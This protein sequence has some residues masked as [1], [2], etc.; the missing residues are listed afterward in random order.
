MV[1]SSPLTDQPTALSKPKAS[2]TWRVL[3]W[4]LLG[5]VMAIGFLGY[6]TP[7]MRL[8]WETIAAMC[9]F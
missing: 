3:G 9:G 1:Q 8:N 7:G 2:L 6:L 5:L 4:S